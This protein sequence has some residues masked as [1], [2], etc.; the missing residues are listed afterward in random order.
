MTEYKCSDCGEW[1]EENKIRT[2]NDETWCDSCYVEVLLGEIERLKE[3][4]QE[5][6]RVRELCKNEG[7]TPMKKAKQRIKELEE[8]NEQQAEK[9]VELLIANGN[10]REDLLNKEK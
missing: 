2:H 6:Y 9:L 1:C 10:L 7:C 4:E 3:Y 5:V 8:V